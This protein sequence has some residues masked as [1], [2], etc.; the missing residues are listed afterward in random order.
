MNL[1]KPHIMHCLIAVCIVVVVVV[2]AVVVSLL[3][4]SFSFF[5]EILLL[6]P[7]N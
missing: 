1:F 7:T 2:F 3:S 5:L 4:I 6:I